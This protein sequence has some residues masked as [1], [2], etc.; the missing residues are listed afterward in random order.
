VFGVG[1]KV[2]Q[3]KD[4]IRQGRKIVGATNPLESAPGTIRG[5]FAIEVGRNII[6]GSDGQPGAAREIAFWFKDNEI[7]DWASSLHGWV[8][9]K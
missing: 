9:E 1:Q 5:D 3:G 8:Y 6:H 4:V 2:W 7:S